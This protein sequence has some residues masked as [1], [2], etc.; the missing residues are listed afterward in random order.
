MWHDAGDSARRMRKR[1][2]CSR[3]SGNGFARWLF[4]LS[5]ERRWWSIGH[6]FSF[7]FC[8]NC[9]NITGFGQM[10]QM[11]LDITEY[12][13]DLEKIK[14]TSAL[15]LLTGHGG[16]ATRLDLHHEAI[17][18]D[19]LCFAVGIKSKEWK[20]RDSCQ[21]AQV[22]Y[23]CLRVFSKRWSPSIGSRTRR[24]RRRRPG[25]WGWRTKHRLSSHSE[26]TCAEVAS[27]VL[28]RLKGKITV[29]A[30][31]EALEGNGILACGLYYGD[32]I[33]YISTVDIAHLEYL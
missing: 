11:I 17:G 28:G 25:T 27:S 24:S 2:P 15:C 31:G 16:E 4:L 7:I 22:L 12:D 32:Y 26:A 8:I 9:M 14:R 13:Y 3:T 20:K 1:W 29:K 19:G 18:D 10:F 23:L 21:S 5:S 6:L 30:A 33:Y